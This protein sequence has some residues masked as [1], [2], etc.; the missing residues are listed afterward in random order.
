MKKLLSIFFILLFLNV[1]SQD[2]KNKE[3]NFIPSSINKSLLQNNITGLLKDNAGYLWISTQYGVYRYDGQ[4]V[5]P[6]STGTNGMIASNRFS[7]ILNYRNSLITID[8][9][10]TYIIHDGQINQRKLDTESIQITNYG[11]YLEL[12]KY[13]L[14]T[15]IKNT[16]RLGSTDILYFKNDT[17]LVGDHGIFNIT[18]NAYLSPFFLRNNNNV[19]SYFNSRGKVYMVN[20]NGIQMLNYINDEIRVNELIE[21]KGNNKFIQY[22]DNYAWIQNNRKLVKIDLVKKK[23]TKEILL[24][25]YKINEVSSCFEDAQKMYI[26]TTSQGIFESAIF[27]GKRALLQNTPA[28][29]NYIYSYAFDSISNHFYSVNKDG[30]F[31]F[32][33]TTNSII[34]IYNKRINPYHLTLYNS[35][36][37]F[38]NQENKIIQFDLTTKRNKSIYQSN[39]EIRKL[40]HLNDSS[41]I[42]TEKNKIF[43]LN[44]LTNHKKTIYQSTTN[45]IITTSLKN[46]HQ[47]WIGFED[48]LINFNW[49]TKKETAIPTKFFV[50]SMINLDSNKLII[51]TYG[52]GSFLYQ[53]KQLLPLKNDPNGISTAVVALSKDEENNLWVLC[54][55]GAFLWKNSDLIQLQKE[56]KHNQYHQFYATNDQIFSEEM[57]GGQIPEYFPKNKIIFPSSNGLLIFPQ[58]SFKSSIHTPAISVRFIAINQDTIINSNKFLTIPAKHDEITFQIDFPLYASNANFNV[59]YKIIGLHQDWRPLSLNRKITVNQLN[60]GNYQI[61]IKID[62]DHIEQKMIEFKVEK[63]WY[64]TYSFFILIGFVIIVCFFLFLKV[65]TKYLRVKQIELEKIIHENTKLLKEQINVISK[66]E[67][68]INKLYKHSNKLYSI[69]MHDLKSPLQFLSSYAVDQFKLTK[70]DKNPDPDALQTIASTSAD[71][72]K[73]INEF[74]Y[75][76]QKQNKNQQAQLGKVD[77]MATLK[78]IVQLYE[79]ISSIQNN[80]ILYFPKPSGI[81]VF[82]DPDLLKIIFRNL[83]DNANK[84]TNN[85][86][87]KLSCDSDFKN[88]TATIIIQDSGQGLPD[89]V[90]TLMGQ[91]NNTQEYTPSINANHKMGIH[92]TK[93]FIQQ[94]NGTLEVNSS[95]ENGT[96]F[97]IHLP[98]FKEH[99][100]LTEK[101]GTH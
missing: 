53:N 100:K 43:L 54:N 28:T 50:R 36:L 59:Q 90:I 69:L 72:F 57:N 44:I 81:Y 65:R 37:Y 99:D 82:T 79:P 66:S 63:F 19:V 70:S 40:D 42:I 34:N 73:Y 13:R 15:Y 25:D 10:E 21:L 47:L 58:S 29:E 83:I 20:Q 32:H 31:Q 64:N 23:I 11:I 85:G 60:A 12:P 30:L 86:V 5:L 80:K 95:K 71:L 26:G 74:L 14:Q 92:I 46:K 39:T 52:M 33:P 84:F 17:I 62:A 88:N 76:L 75:W 2:N 7:Y 8:E 89:Y 91:D 16:S 94:I 27:N 68:E 101:D 77:L 78:E 6:F 56:S 4:N 87:I 48:G 98:L 51:G 61:W 93:E 49:L 41:L 1:C 38:V 35:K 22:K 9:K 67:K 3:W 55:K 97:K 96:I 18:Q 24:N 45:R